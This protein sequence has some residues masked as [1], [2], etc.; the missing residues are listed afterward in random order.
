MGMRSRITAGL[1]LLH[2]RKITPLSA[3]SRKIPPPPPAIM[4]LKI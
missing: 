2:E 1:F 4:T 3:P